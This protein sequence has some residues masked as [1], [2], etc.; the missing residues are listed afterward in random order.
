[1]KL[2]VRSLLNG[3]SK[4][5]HIV[6]LQSRLTPTPFDLED[7]YRQMMMHIEPLY[8]KRA[9][10]VFQLVRTAR[11]VQDSTRE[12]NLRTTPVTV[13]LPALPEEKF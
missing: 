10:E 9:S 3:L 5:D 13:L 12:A 8:S 1:M 11:K 2:V 6:D 7:L 4:W